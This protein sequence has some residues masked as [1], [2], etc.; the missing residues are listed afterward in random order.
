MYTHEIKHR[1]QYYETDAMGIVHH[2]NYIRWFETGR[3]EFLRAVGMP[4]SWL[5]ANQL[6]APVL[7]IECEYKSAAKYD[8]EVTIYTSFAELKGARIFYQYQVFREE[9]LLVTGKSIHAFTNAQMRPI[10][11]RKT[12]P[13]LYQKIMNLLD[14]KPEMLKSS[15]L[16]LP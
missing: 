9:T 1:V 2:S 12:H 8:D 16:N 10:L 4:Y 6:M 14:H 11:L 13:E 7:G 3:T 15:D 5:E